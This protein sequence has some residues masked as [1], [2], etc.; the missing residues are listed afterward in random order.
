MQIIKK[1]AK[2]SKDMINGDIPVI[3][4]LGDSVT[5]GCF[6]VYTT[7][8]NTLDTV[9][10][11]EYGYH[12]Y[13]AKILRMFYPNV[14]V[15]II[16]AGISGDNAVH[17]YERIYKD[18]LNYKPDLVVVSFGLNDSGGGSEKLEQ[19]VNAMENI[20][21]EIKK[22]GCE[23]IFMTANMMNTYVRHDIKEE[24]IRNIARN[25][26]K[27]ENSGGLK[28][29]FDAAKEVAEKHG[30][31]VCDVYSKWRKLAENGVDTT[32]LLANALN[33]PKREMNW[34]FAYSLLEVM[35]NN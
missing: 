26:M 5:Q 24:L 16:N 15:T 18:V 34:L 2:K 7:I 14:P 12:S 35:M 10:D 3:A 27:I 19:Y 25:I 23:G 11:A 29:Y 22:N 8:E 17:G 32:A 33:H 31:L 9:Y 1:I 21:T 13:V 30:V 6:E 28:M 20:F 4:F